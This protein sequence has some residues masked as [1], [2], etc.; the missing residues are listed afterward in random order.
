MRYS[1]SSYQTEQDANKTHKPEIQTR[2]TRTCARGTAVICGHGAR[3]PNI[4]ARKNKK[5][6]NGVELRGGWQN[7]LISETHLRRKNHDEL[8]RLNVCGKIHPPQR[9]I[10]TPQQTT[11]RLASLLCGSAYHNSSSVEPP[12]HRI[13]Y[14]LW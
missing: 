12:T 11:Q 3:C 8:R 6:R 4:C 14:S 1:N 9:K 5:G 13:K 7:I 10:P 2:K